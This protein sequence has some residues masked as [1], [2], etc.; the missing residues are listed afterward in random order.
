MKKLISLIML[1]AS[2][3]L[4]SPQKSEALGG[5][6]MYWRCHSTFF[7]L[8]GSVYVQHP[9]GS[10]YT[11]DFNTYDPKAQYGL[12]NGSVIY[13]FRAPQHSD[14][15]FTVWGSSIFCECNSTGGVNCEPGGGTMSIGDGVL[16][17]VF[18]AYLHC[19]CPNG[20]SYGGVSPITVV[21]CQ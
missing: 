8:G 9:D 19:D 18:Q 20:S 21:R 5:C 17:E 1:A 10:G 16:Y 2:M 11:V 13:A 14:C 7:L 15:A 12:Q 3:L 6:F 4:A